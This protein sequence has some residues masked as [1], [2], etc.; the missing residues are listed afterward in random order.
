MLLVLYDGSLAKAQA[1]V[2]IAGS[3]SGLKDQRNPLVD[4]FERSE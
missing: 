4:K 1:L 2:D 3:N